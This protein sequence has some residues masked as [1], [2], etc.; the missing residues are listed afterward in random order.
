MS[1][2]AQRFVDRLEVGAVFVN[3]LV[4]SDPRMP[5]GGVKDS[6]HGRELGEMGV[7]TVTS[8]KTVW[9]S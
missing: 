7:R 1:Y 9:V 2:D 3:D 5:F 6:G 4:R 8:A